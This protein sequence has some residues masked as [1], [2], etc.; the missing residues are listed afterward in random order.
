MAVGQ[1]KPSAKA[2]VNGF[3]KQQ[4]VPRLGASVFGTSRPGDAR[5]ETMLALRHRVLHGFQTIDQSGDFS[6]P[7]WF[8][9]EAGTARFG[10]AADLRS[11]VVGGEY[12]RWRPSIPSLGFPIVFGSHIAVG[13]GHVRP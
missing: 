10:R 2:Q 8:S 11:D 3:N 13:A 4:P 1:S 7:H 9:K 12:Y 5:S 6:F